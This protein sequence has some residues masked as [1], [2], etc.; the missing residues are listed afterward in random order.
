MYSPYLQSKNRDAD[1]EKGLA[2]T[3][4]EWVAGMNWE[5]G[6]DVYTDTSIK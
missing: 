2:D 6:T 5:S 3:V 1:K 4:G